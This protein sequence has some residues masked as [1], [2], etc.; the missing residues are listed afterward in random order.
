MI[1]HRRFG[2]AAFAIM[3][4][5]S[6]LTM[7]MSASASTFASGYN[8]DKS[9]AKI[10]DDLYVAAFQAKVTADVAGD[11]TFAVV[12]GT[13]DS[14]VEGSVHVIAGRV[15]IRGTINGTLYVA[16]GIVQLEGQ[17]GGNVVVT[18]GRLE[19]HDSA[20]IGGDL[21]VFGGQSIVDG[22]VA[23]TLYGSVLLYEQD[24]S[25]AGDVELQ[26]DRIQ[27][28]SDARI[29]DDFRYQSQTGAN[30]AGSATVGGETVHTDK[31]PW[32]GI[33]GGALAPYGGLTRLLW[34]LL[35]GAVLIAMA[36]RFFY[37]VSRNAANVVPAGI[38]G[39]VGMV[40]IPFLAIAALLSVLLI[41]IGLMLFAV[42]AVAMYL[43][44]V[45]VGLAIGRAILPRKWR[46]GSRG[47]LLLA[48]TIGVLIIGILKLAPV[49]FLGAITMA[50]VTIWGLGA[51]L[52]LLTDLSSRRIRQDGAY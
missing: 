12:S 19:L 5:L 1:A 17:V 4:M 27:I 35:V 36:P 49:P 38:W 15:T 30:I 13:L 45:V 34:S 32:N 37:R 44:Q 21:M 20:R 14:T 10:N 50:I 8:V 24:G 18:G 41:P 2:W 26:A 25:V 11:V 40:L 9:G 22:D 42:Y 3:L 33:E 47:Y 16:A 7:P 52:M 6:T 23:G 29:G 28:G 51:T 48:M 43:S 46:D 39:A 31:S